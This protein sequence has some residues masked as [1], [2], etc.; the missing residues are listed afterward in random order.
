M[1]PAL[2]KWTQCLFLAVLVAWPQ[3][4][5]AAPLQADISAS[6]L[7]VRA[8]RHGLL[9]A[10]AHDHEFIPARWQAEVEF[11]PQRPQEVRVDLRVDA[12][13]L[14]DQVA[15]LAP[16]TR[17]HVD[18]E[19]AGREV[20]DARRYPEIGFHAESAT[21][22]DEGSRLQGVLHG[23]LSLHGATRPLDVRFQARAEGPG[24]RV[25]GSVRFRQTDF[26]MT[27]F[28]TA[29]GTIGVDDEIQ[30][31]FEL[32]LVPASGAAARLTRLGAR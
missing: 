5:Q 31:D 20:L 4:S 14:H 28:S 3:P 29:A 17:E 32:L 24:H 8:G 19:A 2:A 26:G 27:P 6:R 11:D 1:N 13:T 22:R 18:R 21:V 23:A 9:S 25:S 15:R 30:V 7:V 16:K 12:A 10:L